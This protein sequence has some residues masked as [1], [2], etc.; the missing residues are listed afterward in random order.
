MNAHNQTIAQELA[1]HFTGLQY[2]DI[3]PAS[4][5]R[6]K[7]TLLDYLGVGL[8]GSRSES[9]RIAAELVTSAGG[10]P[11]AT[12]IGLGVKVPAADAAFVNAVASHSLEMD[13]VDKLALFHF[14][15]PVVSAAMAAGELAD[16]SGEEFL[17]AIFCGCEM[18][19]RLSRAANDNLR[20]RG[21]H[22][23]ATAGVFGAAVAAAKLLGLTE[24][25]MVSAMGLAGAQSAGL[26]EMYGESMQKRFNP[27]PAA[28]NGV[29]AAQ[30]AKLGFTGAATIFEGERGFLKAFADGGT[31]PDELRPSK[32]G[33]YRLEVEFKPYAC[34]RPIHPANE[35]AQALRPR[36][37]GRL[38]QVERINVYRHPV[39]AHYHT[40]ASPKNYH[41]AQVSLPYAVAVSL[42]EGDAFLDNFE[43][44]EQKGTDV[45][46][47]MHRVR[48]IAEET[49]PTTVACRVEILF[50]GG[51]KLVH[52]VNYAKGSAENPMSPAERAAKFR[53]LAG[54]AMDPQALE[55]LVRVAG[56][57]DQLAHIRQ[58]TACLSG[59]GVQR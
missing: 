53:K 9:G 26:M 49:L 22:T 29:T 52:Q 54:R 43:G 32:S 5:A 42:V 24:A 59:G 33:P 41:E 57:V 31:N 28:R 45:V 20:N 44:A 15:P 50:A 1:A 34:A 18:M 30:L 36:A 25:Q 10:K 35:A 21:F 13:D 8:G 48:I 3:D 56:E 39:W 17:T 23:T 7:T 40:N 51:D 19:E 16:C 58:L 11:E 14:S 2:R 47:L 12:L 38:D 37:L 55:T 4:A 27:A 46:R 6:I